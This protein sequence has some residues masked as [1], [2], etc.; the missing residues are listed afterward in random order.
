M[1][2]TVTEL[3]ALL[4]KADRAGDFCTSGTAE[5]L[6]PSLTVEGVGPISLPLLPVQ[7]AQLV[8]AAE[9]A[10]YGKGPDTIV[11]TTVRNNWQIGPDR[12]KIAGRHWPKT[13]ES[14]LERAAE[15]L[16]VT[17]PIEAEFYKLLIYPRGSFFVPHRDT[18]KTPFMFATLVVVLP[19]IGT[20]GELIVRHKDREV[21]LDLRT[22]DPSEAAF[23]AFY[24]DCLHEVLP[25]TQGCRLTLVYNL[26]RKGKGKA[27]KPPEYGTEQAKVAAVLRTWQDEMVEFEGDEGRSVPEKL[28]YPLEHAYTAPELSFAVLKGADAAAAGVLGAAA[29]EAGCALH[30]ALMTLEESGSAEYSGNYDRRSRYHDDDDDGEFEIGEICESSKTLSQWCAWDGDT[31]S[32]GDIPVKEEELSP[33]DPFAGIDP[34]ELHFEEAS[35]NAGVSF[36]R[37]YRRAALVVWPENRGLAVLTQA[38][39]GV[40]VP[41]LT[42]LARR[43]AA[44]KADPASPIRTQAH[45]LSGYMI[46]SWP[47]NTASPDHRTSAT[48]GFLLALTALQDTDR[49]AGFLARVVAAGHSYGK[50]DNPALVAALQL[51]A[52][53]AAVSS[54]GSIVAAHGDRGFAAC[55]DLL[56]RARASWNGLDAAA[57][58]LLA[59]LPRDLTL[60]EGRDWTMRREPADAG[61]VANLLTGFGEIDPVLADKAV[62]HLLANPRTYGMDDVLVPA[63]SDKLGKPKAAGQPAVTRLREAC[64]AHLRARIALPLAPPADWRRPSAVTCKC[65]HCTALSGFLDNPDQKIWAFAAVQADRDHIESTIAN[66]KPDVDTATLTK[67]RPYTLVCTKNQASYE[68]RA[69]ER[70]R[71]LAN[72]TKL[73]G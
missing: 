48:T 30:L 16:G 12:V 31:V 56:V 51:L 50:P 68:R 5:L 4:G 64:L 65:R 66:A 41:H 35:G 47:A 13:L 23:A 3:A 10:P 26:L 58:T 7:A 32:W 15:G 71:D 54:I 29:K 19:S 20:G 28:V 33:P 63:A 73:A 43:W 45:A 49:I 38:G 62:T 11:D 53:D 42:D 55:A 8:A 46:A 37:S 39:L 9:Q 22:D 67:G 21:R 57:A 14:I 27:P 44:A 1:S 24:A 2:D 18:E 36:E 34:D 52:P 70:R 25:V 72:R 40:T 60:A 61:F 6:A 69:D 59:F 17:D